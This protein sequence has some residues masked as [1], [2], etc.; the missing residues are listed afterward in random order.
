MESESQEGLSAAKA[1]LRR[2]I[3]EVCL[4]GGAHQ[5]NSKGGGKTHLG[6]VSFTRGCA[7][8]SDWSKNILFMEH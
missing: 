6:L 2:Y 1:Y 8:L 3:Y 7:T 5:K 4:F